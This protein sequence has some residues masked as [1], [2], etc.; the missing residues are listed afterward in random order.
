MNE[1]T[2]Q[3]M[4]TS[5]QLGPEWVCDDAEEAIAM[6]EEHG[7]EVLDTVERAEGGTYLVVAG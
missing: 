6:A 7:F 2:Y 3:T 1:D 4:T 5:G